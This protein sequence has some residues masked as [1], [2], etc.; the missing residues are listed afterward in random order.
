MLIISDA[1][2]EGLLGVLTLGYFR[3]TARHTLRKED[4]RNRETMGTLLQFSV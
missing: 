3:I 4:H 1:E 2:M